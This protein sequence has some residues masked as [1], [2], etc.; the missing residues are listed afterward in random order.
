[1][2]SIEKKDLKNEEKIMK[3]IDE[4]LN[5]ED[6]AR[7]NANLIYSLPALSGIISGVIQK[8]YYLNR[9][10][11]EEERLLHEEG[12]W[13]HHQMSQLSPYCAGFSAV[14][15]MKYGL[16]SLNLSSVK[17]KPPRHLR[18]FLDQSSNFILKISQEISG[19][20]AL[21]DLTTVAAAYVWYE[22]EKL[23]KQLT[24]EDIKNAFQSFIYNVNLDFRSGNSPFTNVTITIGGPAPSLSNEPVSI[25]ENKFKVT[26]IT[27]GEIPSEIYDEVNLAFFEVMSEGDS[28]GRPWTFPLITVYI[29][30]DFKWDNEIF[31]KLLELMDNFGGIYLENYI[32][33]PFEDEKWKKLIDNLET[34]DPTLQRSFCCRF[35]I[36]LNELKKVPHSG[37]IFGNISGVGSIG[38]ITINFN[39]LGYIHRGNLDSLFEHLDILLDYARKALNKKREFILNHIDLYPTFFYYVDK[40][41]NTYFNTISLGG[42]HEGLINFGIKDG[43][44]SEEGLE[45]AGKIARHILDKLN[46]FEKEDGIAWNFEYAPMETAAGYL[47]KKDLDFV[48][49]M[50]HG[51]IDFMFK[52]IIKQRIEEWVE[53]GP[54]PRP[55]IP[56]IFVSGSKERPLLT[57]GFQPPFSCKNISKLAYTSAITQNYATGGSV[58]HIF[59]GEKIEINTKKKL[60]KSIFSNYPVKYMT[61]TPT[62]T[63]CN[64]C[65]S[66]FVGEHLVC[67][68]CKSDD[69][70]IYSRVIGY[71]RPIARKIKT[72][73]LQLGLFEGEENTWQES[74]RADWVNRGIIT[75]DDIKSISG[76][77]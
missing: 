23:Q 26:P 20:V 72:K 1:M 31:N 35:Q 22:R 17:S 46:E 55:F 21:N 8:E 51:K 64:N 40:S 9:I 49:Q 50:S 25:G 61:L 71:F 5:R 43:L 32:R 59:L 47:A 75:E 2:I 15:I 16:Q 6:L 11:S 18:T 69:T 73:D 67:P 33:K 39:R 66:K 76:D 44:L 56:E 48:E 42:G 68:K 63:I 4:Y 74:R 29:T 24:Y 10:L 45:L 3:I 7:H 60:M 34:R 58:M 36:N 30:D 27:F 54:C 14:D 19:A 70:T 52:D 41:L 62:L 53:T 12:W 37:S 77:F 38:V 13:Y 28:E 65:K 57:S